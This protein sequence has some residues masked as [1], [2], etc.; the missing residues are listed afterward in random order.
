M[1]HASD[2]RRHFDDHL[3]PGE[4]DVPWPVL[5]RQLDASGFR[6][7][8]ILEIAGRGSTD[9]ILAG[10]ER[11]RAFLQHLAAEEPAGTRH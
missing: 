4:G 6:G 10:A 8:V 1:V 3:P 9:E 5:W 11:A 2:N 7:A